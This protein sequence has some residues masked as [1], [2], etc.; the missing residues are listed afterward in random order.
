MLNY[1]EKYGVQKGYSL[2]ELRST[3][4]KESIKDYPSR[5]TSYEEYC[6][7]LHEYLNGA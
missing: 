4:C 7:A 3:K 5:F 6:D 2:R 1:L